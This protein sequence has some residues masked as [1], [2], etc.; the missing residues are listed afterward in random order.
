VS[1]AVIITL[2]R[3]WRLSW[4][5]T[6]ATLV[7]AAGFFLVSI[8]IGTSVIVRGAR[9]QWWNR[10]PWRELLLFAAMWLGMSAK[11]LWDLIEVRR[12]KNAAL[13]E[14]QRPV[15]IEFDI[16][17]FAQ[18]LLV[19]AIIF[20][21]VLATVREVDPTSFLFSFQNGFFWQT[22]FRKESSLK[23]PIRRGS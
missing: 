13:P 18:P 7:V 8:F 10:T 12:K 23:A 14:G 1:Y 6:V 4:R 16:W 9:D 2:S 21:A 5:L 20:G 15:G 19:S 3:Q 22:V 11:Y 17:D